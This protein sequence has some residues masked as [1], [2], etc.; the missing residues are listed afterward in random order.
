MFLICTW[1]KQPDY[2]DEEISIGDRLIPKNATTETL[3]AL[4]DT[5]NFIEI[6]L[7][8]LEENYEII[9]GMYNKTIRKVFKQIPAKMTKSLSKTNFQKT[10]T[11][12]SGGWYMEKIANVLPPLRISKLSKKYKIRRM[13]LKLYEDNNWCNDWIFQLHWHKLEWVN[14]KRKI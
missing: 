11:E 4:G 6:L 13:K 5:I 9:C 14:P 8:R 3:K 10:M 7:K 12:I 1:Q 2:E